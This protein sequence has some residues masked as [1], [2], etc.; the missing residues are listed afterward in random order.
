MCSSDLYD[1]YH[2]VKIPVIGMGGIC[3]GADAVEFLLAG[4]S[5]VAVGTANFVD[6]YTPLKVIEFIEKYMERHRVSRVSDLVGGAG[7]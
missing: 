2:A 3:D 5:A 4:A 7:K 1:V 6:P